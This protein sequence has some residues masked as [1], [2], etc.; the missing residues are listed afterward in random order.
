M[1]KLLSMGYVT[2]QRFASYWYQIKEV[3]LSEPASVLEVGIGWMA[4][5]KGSSPARKRRDHPIVKP[6]IRAGKPPIVNASNT[7]DKVAPM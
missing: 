6:M 1:S 7:R 3:I 5:I 2:K 4:A